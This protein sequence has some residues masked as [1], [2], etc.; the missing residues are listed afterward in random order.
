MLVTRMRQRRAAQGVPYSEL[1]ERGHFSTATLSTAAS[2]RRVPAWDVVE[3]YVSACDPESPLSDA[4]LGEWKALWEA[5]VRSQARPKA[6]ILDAA[7]PRRGGRITVRNAAAAEMPSETLADLVEQATK[8]LSDPAQQAF[9]S[10][11]MRTALALC[12]TPAD[13][14]ALLDQLR[15]RA[16]LSLREVAERS[17][18]Y[19]GI[20][21]SAAHEMVSGA[22]LPSTEALHVYLLSCGVSRENTTSWHHTATRLKISQIREVERAE[23]KRP[24]VVTFTHWDFRYVMVLITLI[25]SLMQVRD[26]LR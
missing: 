2:G 16:D 9:L 3:A 26:L 15:E 25:L 8:N 24:F 20:S 22:K 11:P 5:A 1:A 4:E 19:G 13:F 12:T 21:K 6:E 23:H 7:V 10:D 17:L 14:S 18:K